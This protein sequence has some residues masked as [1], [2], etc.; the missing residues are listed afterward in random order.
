MSVSCISASDNVNATVVG[1]NGAIAAD[2]DNVVAPVIDNNAP[3]AVDN[4]NVTVTGTY[5]D[6]NKDIQNIVPN[7]VYDVTKDYKFDAK[8]QTIIL[9]DH[10]ITI[11][12]N[13]IIINGNNHTI[14]AGGSKPSQYSRLLETT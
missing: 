9:N 12:Q 1:D 4:V 10:I 6:L 7:S 13:N 3:V 11:S 8:G 2:A 5:D 14:D